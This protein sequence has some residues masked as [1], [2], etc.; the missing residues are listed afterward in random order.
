MRERRILNVDC[1]PSYTLQCPTCYRSIVLHYNGGELDEAECCRYE[2]RLD[3]PTVDLV[4]IDKS[5]PDARQ[6]R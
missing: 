3:A 1:Y 5:E 4:V 6:G 2:F